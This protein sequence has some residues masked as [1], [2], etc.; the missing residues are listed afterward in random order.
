MRKIKI[1]GNAYHNWNDKET[2]KFVG[3]LKSLKMI[4]DING[5]MTFKGNDK[6]IDKLKKLI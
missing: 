2:Q 3:K 4:G 1:S 6:D 5:I